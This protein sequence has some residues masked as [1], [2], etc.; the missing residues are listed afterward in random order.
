M[1][2]SLAQAV[3]DAPLWTQALLVGGIMLVI[4]SGMMM[5][6][7]RK[8]NAAARVT[9]RDRLEEARA[10]TRERGQQRKDLESV[11]LSIEEMARRVGAQ[12]DNKASRVEALLDEAE[13]TIRRL[14]SARFAAERPLAPPVPAPPPS[15]VEDLSARVRRLASEGKSPPTI[16]AE[17]GEH[18]G[19]VELILSLAR[20]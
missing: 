16:A 8:R 7:N 18:V 17:V 6:R 15:A 5:L 10:D 2:V 11:A 12:L 3:A 14:E 19:K 9:A 13:R 4:A 20:E 1:R